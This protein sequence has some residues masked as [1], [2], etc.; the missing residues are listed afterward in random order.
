MSTRIVIDT[1]TLISALGWRLGKPRKIFDKCVAGELKLLQ[2][3]S[4]IE[5]FEKV[6]NRPK[7]AFIP[8]NLKIEFMEILFETSEIIE[9]NISLNV[10]EEDESDNR[11]LECAVCG[12]AKYI[13]SGDEHLLNLKEYAQIIVLNANNF[14]NKNGY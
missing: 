12:D 8:E 7:F 6:I 11:I 10:I 13:I 2:S 4:L 5:E 3:K 9:P 14:L 1:N